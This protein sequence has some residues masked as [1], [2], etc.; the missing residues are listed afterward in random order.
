MKI[1]TSDIDSKN[2][3]ELVW[4]VYQGLK[5]IK[6]IKEIEIVPSVRKG[7]HITVWTS[8]PY[9]KKQIF[10]LRKIIGDDLRRTEIDK[11]RNIKETFFNKKEKL[12]LK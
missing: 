2:Q 5:H 3:L 12:N 1:I 6:S 10:K 11:L 8:F 9:K 4:Y 7:F